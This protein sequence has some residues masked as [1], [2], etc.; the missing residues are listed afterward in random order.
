MGITKINRILSL[1][2]MLDCFRVFPISTFSSYF[3]ILLFFACPVIVFF[4]LVSVFSE[5]TVPVSLYAM[6]M[7]FFLMISPFFISWIYVNLREYRRLNTLKVV[8]DGQGILEEILRLLTPQEKRIGV[9]AFIIIGLMIAFMFRAWID[10]A[11]QDIIYWLDDSCNSI[12]FSYVSAMSI[13][14][15][16]FYWWGNMKF[17]KMAL[18]P[19]IFFEKEYYDSFAKFIVFSAKAFS[20]FAIV[21]FVAFVSF[22]FAYYQYA[23]IPYGLLYRYLTTGLLIL[24]ITVFLIPIMAFYIKF[25]NEKNR[26][27]AV[28]RYQILREKNI[29][30]AILL[31]IRFLC[32]KDLKYPLVFW[33]YIPPSLLLNAFTI[34]VNL[35][36]LARQY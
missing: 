23:E 36:I 4:L 27:L 28:L 35:Q 7:Y 24:G 25:H 16:S 21:T 14:T 12:F 18:E 31:G 22:Y 5:V 6:F 13:S 2:G 17:V 1:G 9:S 11:G 19:Q 15:L 10:N 33:T 26:Q 3:N 29:N 30:K 20:W 34:F 32:I 8:K